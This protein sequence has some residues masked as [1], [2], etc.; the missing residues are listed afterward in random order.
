MTSTVLVH[1]GTE[2]RVK[3][4]TVAM[5]P[6]KN[7][8]IECTYRDLTEDQARGIVKQAERKAESIPRLSGA[9]TGGVAARSITGK[10]KPAHERYFVWD[11]QDLES[12]EHRLLFT[13]R[14]CQVHPQSDRMVRHTYSGKKL[15]F[16]DPC[17]T[18]KV[19]SLGY[20]W[21]QAGD[22]VYPSVMGG[23]NRAV[24]T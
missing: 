2:R 13:V 4:D 19:F 8:I 5:G 7:Q 23:C 24:F 1:G 3:I 9:V 18:A 15:R 17:N 20:L 11:V 22:R 12:P 21:P 14:L 6:G 10:I 16:S